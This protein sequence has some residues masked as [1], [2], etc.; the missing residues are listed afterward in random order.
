MLLTTKKRNPLS[1]NQP[2]N[3]WAQLVFK[4]SVERVGGQPPDCKFNTLKHCLYP[5]IMP[6]PYKCMSLRGR[7]F[8]SSP[9]APPP[10]PRQVAPFPVW[11]IFG[12]CTFLP[13]RRRPP[14]DRVA[15]CILVS[16]WTWTGWW[17]KA[18]CSW[19]WST[20]LFSRG[21]CTNSY[22]RQQCQAWEYGAITTIFKGV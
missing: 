19:R 11:S 16:A 22:N 4:G 9:T 15:S 7:D 6:S 18:T 21:L 13:L 2:L 1:A 5:E 3:N 14:F 10:P 20:Y 8:S 17:A 12:F